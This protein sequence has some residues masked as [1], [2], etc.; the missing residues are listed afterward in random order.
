MAHSK[1]SIALLAFLP[2]MLLGQNNAAPLKNWTTPL[3]WQPNE[4][5]RRVAGQVVPQIQFSTNAVSNTALI[6]IAITPC[7]LVDTRGGAF[8]GMSPFSGPS[9][10]A[11]ATATF[12]VQ[13]TTEASANTAPAPCGVIPTI[14]QAYSFNLTVIPHASGAVDYITMWP[15]NGTQPYVSTLDDPQG[16]IASNDGRDMEYRHRGR[17]ARKQYYRHLQHGQW[18]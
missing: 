17:F 10:A 1:F 2:V 14:A 3:Y 15:A 9:I 13:S 16:I 7:R 12:P 8:N 11:G 4:A 6:F 18:L 5:E